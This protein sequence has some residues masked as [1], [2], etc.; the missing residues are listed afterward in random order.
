MIPDNHE[1]W[2]SN[3]R[4][5]EAQLRKRPVCSIC[6]EPIQDERLWDIEGEL[7]CLDC[8]KEEFCKWTEDYEE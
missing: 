5:K 4:K 6:G 7:Y 1:Q 8:A 2:Q 3:E